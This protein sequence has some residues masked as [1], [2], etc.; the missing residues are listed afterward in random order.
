MEKGRIKSTALA[1]MPF[2]VVFTEDLR[3]MLFLFACGGLSPGAGLAPN[4][5]E[6]RALG[7]NNLLRVLP[8]PLNRLSYRQYQATHWTEGEA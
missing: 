5:C 4:G 8:S 1:N 2:H 7:R 6:F 3:E